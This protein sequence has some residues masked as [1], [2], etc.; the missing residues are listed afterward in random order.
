VFKYQE[1]KNHLIKFIYLLVFSYWT[2][3]S[4]LAQD[5]LR[6]HI[7][8]VIYEQ[9]NSEETYTLP[10][11]NVHWAGTS[12]GTV[13][14]ENGFFRL[15][16]I[17]QTSLLVASF[18]GFPNDTSDMSNLNVIEL[19]FDRSL[20]IEEVEVVFKDK[21]SSV[22]VLDPIQT[23]KLNEE[24]LCKAAC[25]SLSESFE[26]SPSIDVSFTD[27]VTGTRQIRMLG[28]DGK[29]VQ[30]NRELIQDIK[31]LNAIS[32]LTYTPGAWVEGIQMSK[33]TGSVV[34]GYESLTGQ[35]NVE[36]RKPETKEDLFLNVYGDASGRYEVNAILKEK[37][38]DKWSTAMLMHY[39]ERTKESDRN[40]DGFLDDGL[41]DHL[42]MINR[43]KYQ[44]PENYVFQVGIKSSNLNHRNG[45]LG[46][47]DSE[48]VPSTELWSSLRSDDR[49]EGWI[50]TGRVWRNEAESNLG[51]QLNVLSHK[52]DAHYGM[53]EYQTS[54][55]S[56]YVNLIYQQYLLKSKSH[57]LT[58]G[59]SYVIDEIDEN[60]KSQ[61]YIQKDRVPGVFGEYTFDK[62]LWTAVLGMR[63]DVH[64]DFGLQWSPRL[65]VRFLPLEETSIRLVA[66]RAWRSPGVF[67]EYPGVFATNRHLHLHSGDYGTRTFNIESAWNSGANLTQKFFIQGRESTLMLD[68]YYTVFDNQVVADFESDTNGSITISNQEEN[69]TGHSAQF[70]LDTELLPDFDVRLAYRYNHSTAL[71]GKDRQLTPLLS[72][73]KAFINLAYKTNSEW[74]FDMTVNWRSSARIPNTTW[75]PEDLQLE[76]ESPSYFLTNAQIRKLFTQNFEIYVGSENLFD[77]QQRLPI[78]SADDPFGDNFDA[79]NIWG[80][81][82]G[83]TVYAGLRYRLDDIN[84]FKKN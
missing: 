18:V 80:P 51:L 8:G 79:T 39:A 56:A 5:S 29:Y 28:L 12:I 24:E 64:N 30:I 57:K 26:T 73:H 82:F 69:N 32:G 17:H 6:A 36:L 40:A 10:G 76:S 23:I 74:Y 83:R 67:S 14:N 31:G 62:D 50:K 33:G 34:Q 21:S 3:T 60:Y 9:T 11:A 81:V 41:T 84:W 70:Q 37:F 58:S 35:I 54:Q 20:S 38:S 68:Y 25:C 75:L 49:Y 59:I 78:V 43:W 16:R 42:I 7:S 72:P 46:F 22:S 55:K 65:H 15:D 71:Y 47:L 13:T 61:E 45:Q 77:Y 4:L 66:G 44:T 53:N 63:A 1:M 2:C 52:G 27:A 48:T 19:L